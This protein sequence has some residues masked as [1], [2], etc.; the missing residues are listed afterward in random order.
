MTK[1]NFKAILF[2]SLIAAMI[3]P[4]SAMEVYAEET[5]TETNKTKLQD[6]LGKKMLELEI[7]NSEYSQQE[8]TPKIQEKIEKNEK[9]INKIIKKMDAIFDQPKVVKIN[10]DKRL[11]YESTMAEMR[12]SNLPF[13]SMGI[14]SYTGKITAKLDVDKTSMRLA[15]ENSVKKWEDK[16]VHITYGK[17]AAT[18]QSGSCE[19]QNGFCDPII[20]ASLGEPD[21]NLNLPCT[22]SIVATKGSGSSQQKGVVIPHHCN[23]QHADY[24]QHDRHEPTHK[25][26]STLQHGGWWCDCDFVKAD[27]AATTHK[28][29]YYG[30]DLSLS[31][32]G[33]IPVNSNVYM[34][35]Q[36]SG[37]DFGTIVA[38]DVWVKVNGKWHAG[39]QFVKNIN[40]DIGDSGAPL[41]KSGKYG[42]MNFGEGTENIN[43]QDT[44]VNYIHKWSFL[45]SDLGLN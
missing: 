31:S 38:T 12:N 16:D 2:A 14:D 32:Y 27:R 20:G 43:G 15:S 39:V 8:Q 24:Y 35:G 23:P 10:D 37:L 4:F 25:V 29:N 13:L 28:L 1:N 33:D 41:V 18:Y 26:G 45:K 3:L 21:T 5:T 11:E 40:Y 19:S 22:I 9:K 34:I 36:E 44:H 7:A 17:D 30:M 6:R 42:G